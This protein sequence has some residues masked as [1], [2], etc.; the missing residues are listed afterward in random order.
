MESWKDELYHH[1]ILGQKWGVRR[2][3]NEDGTLTGAGRKRR[4]YSSTSLRG[5][6]AKAKNR[7]INKSFEEWKIN[8]AK[9]ADAIEKGIK[10][11][12]ARLAYERD[13]RNKDLK[14]ESKIAEKEYKKAL[15]SNTLYR[16][17]SVRETVGKDRSTKYLTEA[18]NVDKQL[19]NDP[20]NR[21]LQKKYN[22]YMTQYDI[23]RAKARKAQQVGAN[24]SYR[25][26][27]IKRGMTITVKAAATA[28]AIGAGV[29]FANKYVLN[30]SNVKLNSDVVSNAIN[31]G[32]QALKF[33]Y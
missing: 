33:M 8:D 10:A 24:R 6:I 12:D 28:A 5:A 11:N 19:R 15:R 27:A 26:A 32:R 29:H 20:Y 7:K 30:N 22:R 16:Q 18:K 1:G 31:I 2:Y 25:V 9:K 23:N 3:Q 17:G 21:D 13:S 14:K 4:A